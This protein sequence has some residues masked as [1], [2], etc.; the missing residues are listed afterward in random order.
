MGQKMQYRQKIYQHVNSLKAKGL[1]TCLY[2]E[3]YKKFVVESTMA[4]V[5]ANKAYITMINDLDTRPENIMI[6]DLIAGR[7]YHQ[8][9][10]FENVKKKPV[11]LTPIL[12]ED[13]EIYE[14]SGLEGLKNTRICRLIEEAYFQNALF[15]TQSLSCLLNMGMKALR[16]RLKQLWSKGLRLPISGMKKEHRNQFKEF[17]ASAA[18][19]YYLNGQG[20]HTI[21]EKLYITHRALNEYLIKFAQVAKLVDEINDSSQL[22]KKLKMDY[23]L[24]NEYMNLVEQNGSN[25]PQLRAIQAKL[26]YK[27]KPE[28]HGWEGFVNDLISNHDWSNAKVQTYLEVLESYQVQF[29][30]T[31]PE[32]T[33]IY[34][35][36]SADEPAGKPLANAEIVP[37]QIKYCTD[38]NFEKFNGYSM[39]SLKWDKILRYT[40]QARQQGALLNQADLVFLLGI[41]TNAIQRL[42]KENKKVFVPTR[43]NINDI[44]PGLT[45]AEDI[46][47]YYMQGY[48]ET[49]IKQRT[50]HSY[51]S[52]E[53]YI[54]IFANVYGLLE[55]GL[56]IGLIRMVLGKSMKLMKKY[57]ALYEQYINNEEFFP[58]FI[59]LQAIF[60]N[61]NSKKK[62]K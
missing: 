42:L 25:C 18:V 34:H 19:R 54:R 15:N 49:A 47:K 30:E 56:P 44:G 43:G 27:N 50:G 21:C 36:V 29:K 37:I 38:D 4:E 11:R 20:A 60:E 24:I 9:I 3:T 53:N 41:S 35:A 39:S 31:R 51:D 58:V 26:F 7:N 59:R 62:N 52:I 6:L 16:R 14:R 40:T 13:I 10:S 23:Q 46:I 48:T 32:K 8:K 1:Y 61:Q 12:Y 5:V 17:R 33:I 28:G 45:H 57:K 55:K 22:A 2:T